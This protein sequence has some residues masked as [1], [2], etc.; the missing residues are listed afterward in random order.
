MRN[1]LQMK[2]KLALSFVA[3]LAATIASQTDALARNLYVSPDGNGRNGLT[4]QTAWSH[5]AK[6]DWNRVRPGDHIIIDGG[7]AGI[8]YSGAAVT[9]PKSHVVLRQS[10]EQGHNGNI[11]IFGAY[12]YPQPIQV[13][14]TF[15]GNDIHIVGIRRSGIKVTTY[16][17]EC[18]RMVGN[19][20]TMRNVALENLTGVPPYG[21]GMN[22]GLTFGGHNNHVL[23]C[24]FRFANAPNTKETPVAGAKNLTVFRGCTFGNNGYGWWGNWGT[25]IYAARE[26][27]PPV[28]SSI[29]VDR[30]VFGPYM[31]RGIDFVSGNLQVTNTSF[32]G[33]PIANLQFEPAAGSTARVTVDHCTFWEPNFQGQS[34]YQHP[35][36][37]ISTNGNGTTTVSNS[38]A[39][40][41]SVH[42]PAGQVVDGGGNFQYR[43]TG[44]TMA[45][46]PTIVNPLYVDDATLAHSV[47]SS[48]IS[49][50]SFTTQSYALSPS[51]PATGKG[52]PIADVTSIVPAYGPTSG[53]P[54]QGGP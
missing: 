47:T 30:C 28:A 26:A 54:P 36:Y 42:V 38:I 17:A 23:N 45:L 21:G 31:N 19:N 1:A 50:R 13:G 10:N 40:G 7:T 52:S 37:Q 5:P 43:I 24:D 14:I 48:T 53:L 46:A 39:Y 9:I 27:N 25:G 8:T 51:S 29:Y 34:P 4:W 3:A 22:A 16:A 44:N 6:I 15:A 11:T 20:C 33:A 41:G 12:P 35:L 49:P 32:L 2:S 18:V